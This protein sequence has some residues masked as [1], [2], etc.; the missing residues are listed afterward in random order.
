MAS[1]IFVFA[2]DK[3]YFMK[4]DVRLFKL[5]STLISSLLV[6][7]ACS[8][9]STSAHQQQAKPSSTP[10]PQT[11]AQ[12]I[13]NSL[14]SF[15]DAVN[16][17]YGSYAA[18]LDPST[19]GEVSIAMSPDGKY[20]T[21]DYPL[22]VI[23][24]GTIAIGQERL[25]GQ[26]FGGIYGGPGQGNPFCGRYDE[27]IFAAILRTYNNLKLP[28]PSA[29]IYINLKRY[30]DYSSTDK[31]GN[32]SKGLRNYPGAKM[33]ITISDFQKTNWAGDFNLRQLSALTSYSDPDVSWCDSSVPA[34]LNIT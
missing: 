19:S 28:L 6:L 31:Y 2:L 15:T 34:V 1:I 11:P 3:E 25:S 23:D 18:T 22:S 14:G 16:K 7:S 9:G 8:S 32:K 24:Y 10:P 5:V 26:F 33:G 30:V 29:G 13:A 20:V 21:V 12:L 27:A 4:M 17:V